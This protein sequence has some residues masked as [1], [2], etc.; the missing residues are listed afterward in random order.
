MISS[1]TVVTVRKGHEKQVVKILNDFVQKEKKVKGCLKVYLRKAIDNLDTFLVYA[2][3][4][5]KESFEASNKL[6]EGQKNSKK[7]ILKPHVMKLF[8]GNFE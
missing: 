8:Y 3:Y 1:L 6:D 4:D 2:E 7:F 5:S